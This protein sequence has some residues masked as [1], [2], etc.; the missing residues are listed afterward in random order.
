[1]ACE[2]FLW[3]TGRQGEGAYT[4]MKLATLSMRAKM[5]ASRARL[6]AWALL[7]VV[8]AWSA[9]L[10]LHFGLSGKGFDSTLQVPFS[11]LLYAPIGIVIALKRPDNSIGWLYM[12]IGV[13]NAMGFAARELF[14]YSLLAQHGAMPGTEWAALVA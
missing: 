12:V 2:T 11:F 10:V 3:P 9:A 14:A 4:P 5:A 1:M 7:V 8:V 6:P 13:S